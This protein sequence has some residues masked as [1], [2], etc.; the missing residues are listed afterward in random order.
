MRDEI[1]YPFQKFNG[2][3]LGIWLFI[4]AVIKVSKRDLSN[5]HDLIRCIQNQ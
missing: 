4:H 3:L 2:N 1:T 5:Q